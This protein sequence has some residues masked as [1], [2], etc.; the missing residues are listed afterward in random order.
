MSEIIVPAGVLSDTEKRMLV[1]AKR[2]RL[3]KKYEEDHFLFC[4]DILGYKDIDNAMHRG[5]CE[6]IGQDSAELWLLPRGHLKSSLITIG[7]TLRRIVKNPNIRIL[8]TNATA[9]NAEK[10]LGVMQNII[11]QNEAF[12]FF[13][14]HLRPKD[15]KKVR[16]NQAELTV[17]RKIIVPESTVETKGVGG[18]LV[19]RHYD[20]IVNDDIVNEDNCNTKE[21]RENL[22]SWHQLSLSL[23]EPKGQEV[24]LGTRYHYEDLYDGMIRSGAYKVYKRSVC[25]DNFGAPLDI[26]DP[27]AKF[28]FP[29]KFDLE[30]IRTIKQRQGSYHFSCQYYNEPVDLAT[31]PFKESQFKYFD[32]YK[33]NTA[34]YTTVD[35]ST[36]SMGKRDDYA[37]VMTCGITPDNLLYVY[38]YTYGI[39]S[40]YDLIE[41]IFEHNAKYQPVAVGVESNGFQRLIQIPLRDA[42]MKRKIALPIVELRPHNNKSK[43]QRILALQPRFENGT[44][45]IRKGQGHLKDQLRRFPKGRDDILDAL[46]YQLQ[47]AVPPEVFEYKSE[48]DAKKAA[49]MNKYRPLFSTTGY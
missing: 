10:F 39:M 21:Q 32:K 31:A 26:E 6:K 17:A 35:P 33:Y 14:S 23:L 3:R 47:V 15:F 16:W 9:T 4:R 1:A 48:E 28:I 18:N 46:A 41:S 29:N 40:T 38:E 11:T 22:E 42:M 36:G 44:I 5:I 45:F 8:I 13:W 43:A 2:S 30:T 25:E 49:L 27:K 7:Y 24:V 19:S 37:V 20:L 34:F 12:A